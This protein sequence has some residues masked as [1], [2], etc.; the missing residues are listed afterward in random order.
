MHKRTADDVSADTRPA[1][2]TPSPEPESTEAAP[3]E[4]ASSSEVTSAPE[5]SDV[6]AGWKH[7]PQAL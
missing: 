2:A 7:V 3:V 5:A 4:S 1:E 6:P